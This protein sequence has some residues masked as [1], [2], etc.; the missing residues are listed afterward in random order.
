[1]RGHLLMLATAVLSVATAAAAEP[2]QQPVQKAAQPNTRPAEV[3]VASVDD[4]RSPVAAAA[5]D[6][7]APV[8]RARKARVNSC[9]CGDQAASPESND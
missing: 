1:M 9:R 2:A 7:G 3:L 5:Q 4:V 6:S 8:K